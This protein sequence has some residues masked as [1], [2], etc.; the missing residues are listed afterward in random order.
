MDVET[1]NTNRGEE[2]KGENRTLRKSEGGK[3]RNWR[4]K[5]CDVKDDRAKVKHERE[6]IK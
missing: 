4:G 3:R 5:L 2:K 1:W 6:K